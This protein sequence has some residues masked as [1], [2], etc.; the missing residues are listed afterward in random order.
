MPAGRNADYNMKRN[1][2]DKRIFPD[3]PV[4]GV[5]V[6]VTRLRD[7]TRRLSRDTD[8]YR[9]RFVCIS[10]VHTTVMAHDDPDY[11]RI[12]K[13]ALFVSPDGKP[14]VFV[15]RR[16]GYAEAERVAGPDLMP[17]MIEA[18]LK[19]GHR[20]YFYGSSKKTL[21]LMRRNLRRRF[22][23]MVIAGMCAPPFRTL[24]EEEDAR[25]TEKINAAK[26][27][28]VW[29]GLGAPKQEKWMAQHAGRI[30]ALMLGVGAAFDFE[31]GTKKRAPKW[32]QEL[33]LEWLFR[34]MQD[35]RRLFKRY[36]TTNFRFVLL[37]L[38]ERDREDG[39]V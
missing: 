25:I 28:Y 13:E 22:P 39:A 15:C 4:L 5:P 26:P 14:L 34:L 17:A 23:D 27:D 20:H 21:S 33:Y 2:A 1:D 36:L 30:R 37:N 31:A 3:C 24:T 7:V 8:R 32:M 10:N 11:M 12:Q 35:P 38:R 18:G 29:V 16:R 6:A 9:G 19:E